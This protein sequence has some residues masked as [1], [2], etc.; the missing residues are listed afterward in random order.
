MARSR[1]T[2]GRAILA[3]REQLGIPQKVLA[4]RLGISAS[5]LSR[6]ETGTENPGLTS[7]VVRKLATE[8]GVSLDDITV[9]VPAEAMS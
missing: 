6:I 5:Y 1:V 2:N 4:E 3:K 8:L 9:P 7:V